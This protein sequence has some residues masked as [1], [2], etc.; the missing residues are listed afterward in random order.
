MDQDENVIPEEAMV[1]GRQ[2]K[3]AKKRCEELEK[4]IEKGT[5]SLEVID[6]MILEHE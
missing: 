6:A 3:T 2:P 1:M 5:Q 4:A